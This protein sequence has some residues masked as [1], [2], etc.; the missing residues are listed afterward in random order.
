MG[1]RGN[2]EGSIYY[3][4][5]LNRWVGQFS[6]GY[7]TDGKLNRKS[8]YGKTRKEVKD[9]INKALTEIKNETFIDRNDIKLSELLNLALK[10]QHEANTIT[11]R[12]YKRKQY[13][14]DIIKTTKL[15]NMQIQ[16]IK[17]SDINKELSTLTNYSNSTID[18][19]CVTIKSAFD[20]AI[21][22]NKIN[23]NPF[24]IK[25]AIIKPKSI[26][27]DKKIDSLTIEEQYKFLEELNKK[28]YTYKNILLVALFTGMRIGEI[29][30]LKYSDINYEN[31]IIKVQRTMTRDLE[32]KPIIGKTTK[33]ENGIREVHAPKHII[34]LFNNCTEEKLIFTNNNKLINVP[35]INSNFKRI[36]KNANIREN[37]YKIQ[38]NDKEINLKTSNV[39]THMLRHTYA[40]R[41]IEAG[42]S[43]V[44]LQKQLGHKDIQTTLNTYTTIFNKF[45]EEEL[46]KLDKYLEK[47]NLVT[48]KLH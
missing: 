30:A 24:N 44:I 5:T 15:F 22:L 48:L 27:E 38:R 10:E 34:D 25:G 35:T 9:K 47:N 13:T 17:S 37:I 23:N 12:T 31:K 42:I 1:K 8:V 4:E 41:C 32:D 20:K 18:K 43:P 21:L 46:N 36:C 40:T 39:N 33:T 6:A 2:G 29:L 19:I 3:S 7:K 28:D 26:K 45:K 14:I 16:K 11:D